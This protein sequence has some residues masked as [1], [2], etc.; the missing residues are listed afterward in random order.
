MKT[1]TPSLSRFRSGSVSFLLAAVLMATL[2]PVAAVAQQQALFEGQV[3]APNDKPVANA[4][5]TLSHTEDS[6]VVLSG[7]SDKKGKFEI[8]VLMPG[9]YSILVE[10]KGFGPY[11]NSVIVE[12][13]MEY[14][15]KLKLM[16]EAQYKQQRSVEAFNEGV[17]SLQ[18]GDEESAETLFK[19]S[20]QLNP[21]LPNP[22][23]G[24]ASLYHGQ[25]RW[26][27]AQASLEKFTAVVPLNAQLAPLAWDV[28]WELGDEGKADAAL[29]MI[30][31]PVERARLASKVYNEG[32]K[33]S[34]DDR[35]DEAI[36][37]FTQASEMDPQNPQIVQNMAAIEFNRKAYDKALPHL[38]R[39]L[40]IKPDSGEGRRLL[41]YSY[42]ELGDD[43]VNDALGGFLEVAG[44]LAVSD[45]VNQAAVDFEGGRRDEAEA[46]LRTLVQKKPEVGIGHYRL[47]LVLASKGSNEE[48]KQHLQHFLNREPDHEEVGA[49]KAMLA[50]L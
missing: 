18:G 5:I 24:L 9:P 1:A 47:G 16:D 36:T 17:Q 42:R 46:T 49:A 48:A 38:D 29:A 11:K 10:R 19:E 39:L 31:D 14:K 35:D 21:G 27:D 3:M 2:V 45:I 40:G 44:P 8:I 34:Q 26:Q 6:S 4:E 28:Y 32:V 37:F 50:E 15:A 22:H 30:T 13:G 43:Q 12:T 25:E 7:M 23:V 33:A 41:Y 20:V